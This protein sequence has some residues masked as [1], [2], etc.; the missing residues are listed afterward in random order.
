MFIHVVEHE[1]GTEKLL[2]MIFSAIGNAGA[3]LIVVLVWKYLLF[4]NYSV[5]GHE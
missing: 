2:K 4:A 3:C 5:I 1:D